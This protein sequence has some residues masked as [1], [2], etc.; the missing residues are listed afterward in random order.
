MRKYG[1]RNAMLVVVSLVSFGLLAYIFML[2]QPSNNTPQTIRDFSITIADE[3]VIGDGRMRVV[4]G[5]T[6]SISV[7]SNNDH[8]L[9]IHGYDTLVN[10]DANMTASIQFVADRPGRFEAELH[11]TDT[12]V[13]VLEVQPR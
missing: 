13:F 8:E 7:L 11:D 3:K 6:V 9:H 12:T 10:L 1:K 5:D 4:E 2:L